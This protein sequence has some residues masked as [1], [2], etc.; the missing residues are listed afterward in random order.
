MLLSEA[1]RLLEENGY[2]V[3]KTEISEGKIGHALAAGALAL[4]LAAGNADALSQNQIDNFEKQTEYS[5]SN[6]DKINYGNMIAKSYIKNNKYYFEFKWNNENKWDI[7]Y[8]F[9]LDGT[10]VEK[11]TWIDNFGKYHYNLIKGKYENHSKTYT[12]DDIVGELHLIKDFSPNMWRFELDDGD[13]LLNKTN[14]IDYENGKKVIEHFID[15][16]KVYYYDTNGNI[17]KVK[18]FKKGKGNMPII[19]TLCPD[20]HIVNGDDCK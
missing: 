10:Y 20:G 1:K 11:Q 19:K 5:I 13:I 3:E 2:I 15:K 7:T 4:G 17:I 14:V 6:G 18:M 9:E 16:N 12:L 8:R